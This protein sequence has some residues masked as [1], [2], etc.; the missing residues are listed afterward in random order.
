MELSQLKSEIKNS[1][2]VAIILLSSIIGDNGTKFSYTL[3]ITNTQFSKIRKT[4]VN[5]SAVNKKLSKTQVFKMIQL[6][7]VLPFFSLIK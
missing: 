4:S 6:G 7:G 1:T 5:G 2:Q 3:L